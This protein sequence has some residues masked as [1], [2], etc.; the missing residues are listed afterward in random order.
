M[1]KRMYTAEESLAAIKAAGAAKC[2]AGTG[3]WHSDAVTEGD[4]EEPSQNSDSEPSKKPLSMTAALDDPQ[5]S[6]DP[7][8]IFY[9]T[10]MHTHCPTCGQSNLPSLSSV[11]RDR[12]P[13]SPVSNM[14]FPFVVPMDSL[15][16]AAFENDMS[17]LEELRLLKSQLGDVARVCNAV[18][19]GI[20]AND[21]VPVQGVVMFSSRRYQYYG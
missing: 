7:S 8:N 14:P 15:A 2:A 20:L 6:I 16:A 13:E 18:A 4:G 11:Q 9:P 5:S 12:G 3:K 21:Y 10:S 17:T 1:A 19:R